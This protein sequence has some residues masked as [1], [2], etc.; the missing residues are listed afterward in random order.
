MML[1]FS[2]GFQ[3]LQCLI[4]FKREL[5]M[6]YDEYLAG[7]C[8]DFNPRAKASRKKKGKSF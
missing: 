5:M 2:Q 3:A 4:Y 8:L 1:F 6:A 7:A